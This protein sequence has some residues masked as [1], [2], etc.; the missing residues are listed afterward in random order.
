[1]VCYRYK[2][3]DKVESFVSPINLELLLAINTN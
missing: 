1:M 3:L 2:D